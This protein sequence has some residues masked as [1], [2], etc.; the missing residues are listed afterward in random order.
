MICQT[1]N[2]MCM[3]H[4][5]AILQLSTL[6]ACFTCFTSFRFTISIKYVVSYDREVRAKINGKG[7]LIRVPQANSFTLMLVCQILEE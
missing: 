6:N 3:I 4:H 7:S 5:R 2:A 1:C